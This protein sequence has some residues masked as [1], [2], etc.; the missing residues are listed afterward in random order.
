MVHSAQQKIFA[1]SG[2]PEEVIGHGNGQTKKPIGSFY[3]Q[4]VGSSAAYDLPGGAIS[5]VS[6]ATMFKMSPMGRVGR[7]L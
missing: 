3:V 4:F 1:I 2:L 5:M 7:T 6:R